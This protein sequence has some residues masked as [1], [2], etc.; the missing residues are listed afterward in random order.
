M[1]DIKRTWSVPTSPRSP[2][3]LP[4]ELKLLSEF[5]GQIWN[6]HTQRRFAQMLAESDFYEGSVSETLPDFSARDRVNRSP[7]TF[8]FAR[9]DEQRRMRITDAGRRLIEGARIEE[10]FTRQ[11]LKWQYP[12]PKHH[13]NRYRNFNI[14]PFVETLRL[15]YELDGLSKR[16]IAIFC[17]PLIDFRSYS[18]V[19]AEIIK[20]RKELSQLKNIEKRRLVIATH[21]AYYR[22]IFREE[23]SS[24]SFHVRE[25]RGR[26]PDEARFIAT[27]VRNSMDYADAAVRYFRATGL[28]KLSATT[29]RLQ[30][31]ESKLDLVKE[32]LATTPSE[33]LSFE[34]QEIFLD[35]LGNPDLPALPDDRPEI[36]QIEIANLVKAISSKALLPK[37]QLDIY[38]QEKLVSA[39]VSQLKENRDKLE[40]LLA[41]DAR[42]IQIT[43][44][45]SYSLYDDIIRMYEKIVHRADY[46]IP[47]KPL[48]FEWNTWRAFAMLDDGEIACNAVLDREGKPLS[49]APGGMPDGV[50][51]YENFVLT[52]EVTLARGERQFETEN[53]SVPRHLGKIIKSMRENGDE[54]PAFGFFIASGLNMSTVAHF[55]A[56]RRSNVLHYGGKAKIVPLDLSAFKRMLTVARDSGGMKAVQLFT[57]LRWIDE[58]ADRVENEREWYLAIDRKIPN[59]LS[60][61]DVKK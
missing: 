59:W 35:F 23:L 43:A 2:Y 29:F 8:G 42:Q 58:K 19:K 57:F 33:S 13:G 55:Y 51:Y 53:E 16:E 38:R 44:L 20:F 25:S 34:D 52:I 60:I 27:K 17:L 15:V 28:F 30:V 1:P 32:I 37:E 18:S 54:R 46:D 24:G 9:F 10:L 48:F 4:Q 3:K 6:K 49:T 56:L 36:L 26:V 31:M 41:D 47:D 39:T 14:R 21:A 7:K 12:S 45:Q 61:K 5:E 50:G 40:K 22:K 11:L